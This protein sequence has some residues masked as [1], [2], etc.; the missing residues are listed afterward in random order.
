[1]IL[2][3]VSTAATTVVR[4][5][6][7][8]CRRRPEFF[9]HQRRLKDCFLLIYFVDKNMTDILRGF[10]AMRPRRQLCMCF[11]NGYKNIF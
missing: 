4:F 3:H 7:L 6:R 11:K 5:P 1:M 9:T 10:N 8:S 2:R